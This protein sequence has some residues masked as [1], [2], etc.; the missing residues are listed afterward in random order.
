M[1]YPLIGLV[2]INVLFLF[3]WLRFSEWEFEFYD[4][5]AFVIIALNSIIFAY[6]AFSFS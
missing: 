6:I 5:I 1:N 4:N 3:A 2:I